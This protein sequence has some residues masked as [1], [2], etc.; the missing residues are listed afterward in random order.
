MANLNFHYCSNAVFSIS[1]IESHDVVLREHL[2]L[3]LPVLKTVAA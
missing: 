1:N 3:L 2:L